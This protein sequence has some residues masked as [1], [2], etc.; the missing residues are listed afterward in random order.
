MTEVKPPVKGIGEGKRIGQT[1]IRA[2]W[3][4]R[5][6][7]SARGGESQSRIRACAQGAHGITPTVDSLYFPFGRLFF[8]LNGDQ[9]NCMRLG[10]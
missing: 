10:S 2:R 4:V 6:I 3:L 1:P 9:T 7:M 8:S 5:H